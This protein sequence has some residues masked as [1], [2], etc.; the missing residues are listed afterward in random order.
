M[1][2]KCL[3]KQIKQKLNILCKSLSVGQHM[4][5][6]WFSRMVSKRSFCRILY[7]D[8]QQNSSTGRF[9]GHQFHGTLSVW[10]LQHTE[11][12][13][14][15]RIMQQNSS[16][17]HSVE[18]YCR[19]FYRTLF[20]Q[21]ILVWILQDIEITALYRIMHLK[22]LQN[23]IFSIGLCCRHGHCVCFSSIASNIILQK[24]DILQNVS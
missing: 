21:N 13:S 16:M 12:I 19:T 14:F 4:S 6:D 7:R 20:L 15:Y 5:V 10:I 1:L 18:Q 23:A 8:V 11:I 17:G 3:Q 24:L 9:I 22:I 2:Q